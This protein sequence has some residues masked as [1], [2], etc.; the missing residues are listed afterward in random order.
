MITDGERK[1]A[2]PAVWRKWCWCWHHHT[3]LSRDNTITNNQTDQTRSV[4]CVNWV[5]V[6]TCDIQY[7]TD[8]LTWDNFWQAWN[9]CL[10]NDLD[11]SLTFQEGKLNTEKDVYFQKQ[12]FGVFN[13]KP[14][15]ISF[16]VT[17]PLSL[18]RI[19]HP[20]MSLDALEWW[21]YQWPLCP[22][23]DVRTRTIEQEETEQEMK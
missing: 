3:C 17:T 6:M 12:Y 16:C 2:H 13:L 18:I 14:I 8:I 23:S 10:Q 9:S 11:L 22:V 21:C 5:D 7:P 19:S 4:N 1:T 20:N 15:K